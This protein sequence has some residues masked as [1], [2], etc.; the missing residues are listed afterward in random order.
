ML[1]PVKVPQIHVTVGASW[2]KDHASQGFFCA[3]THENCY[4]QIRHLFKSFCKSFFWLFLCTQ[5]E[6]LQRTMRF[7]TAALIIVAVRRALSRCDRNPT[8]GKNKTL[9]AVL[10]LSVIK[11][12]PSY[13][14]GL[15][16]QMAVLIFYPDC[17]VHWTQLCYLYTVFLKAWMITWFFF[18]W[19]I[20][21]INKPILKSPCAYVCS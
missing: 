20:W 7:S 21:N 6:A 10:W 19:E 2:L 14:Q 12:I 1:N 11:C 16:L 8:L 9:P 17:K 3:A 5:S 15:T 4:V 13:P 18:L